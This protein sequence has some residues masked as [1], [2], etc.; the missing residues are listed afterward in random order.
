MNEGSADPEAE[1]NKIFKDAEEIVRTPEVGEPGSYEWRISI[2][3]KQAALRQML[4]DKRLSDFD[5]NVLES[6]YDFQQRML[7]EHSR[8]DERNWTMKQRTEE[9][10]LE[11]QY[12]KETLEYAEA[13]RRTA[14]SQAEAAERYARNAE[15]Q[16]KSL[17]RATWV[18]AVA[19]IALVLATAVLI[20]VTATDKGS[21]GSRPEPGR[22][23]T[24]TL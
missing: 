12:R 13:S 24:A 5:R 18:L 17:T 16:A 15:T 23:S 21:T 11:G 8:Q 20:F 19:T 22:T 7:D 10:K 9:I 2:T 3:K 1:L 6:T 14:E 4:L